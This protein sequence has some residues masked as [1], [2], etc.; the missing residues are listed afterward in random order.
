ML[1]Y[2]SVKKLSICTHFPVVEDR[3]GN[4]EMQKPRY[5][6]HFAAKIDNGEKPDSFF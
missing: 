5:T 2:F 4:T 3:Y 6:P 1:L